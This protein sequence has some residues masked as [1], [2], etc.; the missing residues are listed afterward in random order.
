MS[1]Q[2]AA[3]NIPSPDDDYDIALYS[4]EDGK[5]VRTVNCLNRRKYIY[6]RDKEY[7]TDKPF[8]IPEF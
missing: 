8:K 2:T 7:K 3:S 6:L 1:W 5:R 4:Q